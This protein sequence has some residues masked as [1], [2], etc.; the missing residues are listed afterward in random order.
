MTGKVFAA[1]LSPK[2]FLKNRAATSCPEF[3]MSST[4]T[5]ATYATFAK[6]YSPVIIMRETRPALRAVYTG[7]ELLT[8]FNTFRILSYPI[9]ED[10]VLT[11]AVASVF[12]F[13]VLPCHTSWKLA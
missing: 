1:K 11:S 10:V 12:G 7:L 4:G 2:T 6:M 9:N 13:R 5:A 8:S 3:L